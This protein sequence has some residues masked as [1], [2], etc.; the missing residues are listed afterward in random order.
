[1]NRTFF[2]N[3]AYPLRYNPAGYYRQ[4][5]SGSLDDPLPESATAAS[6]LAAHFRQEDLKNCGK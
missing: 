2:C 5:V 3:P 4:S 6:V 1:M